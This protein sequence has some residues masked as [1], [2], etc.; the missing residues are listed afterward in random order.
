MPSAAIAGT[1][2]IGASIGLGL[3]R[4]NWEVSGWDPD[5][6][7]LATALEMGAIG[8]AVSSFDDLV[9]GTDDV[10]IL[11]GPP[12]AVLDQIQVIET[13]SLVIDVAGVKLEAVERAIGK[14]FVGTHPMAGREIRGPA[15]ATPSLFRGATWVITTDGAAEGDLQ[16]IETMLEQLGARPLRMTAAEHD[17]G[18]AMISHLPQVLATALVNEA[19]DRTKTLE[20]VAGSFRDLTRVAASDPA[21]W[22]DVLEL[23]TPQVLAV[24]EDFRER[25]GRVADALQQD[26]DAALREFLG[27]GRQIR[28]DLA[29]GAVAVR[30]ALADQPGELAR[31]GRAF[32][33]ASVDIRDLQ[34]RHA[35]HGGGGVLTVSVRPGE[36]AALRTALEDEGLLVLE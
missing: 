7:A 6:A 34:L 14:R 33:A 4:A 15:A 24:I 2:L 22:V 1:G 17:A 3:S 10:V 19:A 26:D 18:V 13:T 23:N 5:P 30:V 27:R 29:P 9:A 35:P 12:R 32:G 31:V 8:T 11:G 20:L 21:N 16:F 25:L 28:R 36:D